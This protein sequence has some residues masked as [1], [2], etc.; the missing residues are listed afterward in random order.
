VFLCA[1]DLILD[2]LFL[3][4]MAKDSFILSIDI[5]L[6]DSSYREWAFLVRTIMRVAGFDHLTDNP[7]DVK[8]DEAMRKIW[9]KSDAKVTCALI[10]NICASLQMSLQNHSSKKEIRMYLK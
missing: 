2:S 9:R 1:I 3:D 10:L 6:D 8:D 7:L 4:A 5:K